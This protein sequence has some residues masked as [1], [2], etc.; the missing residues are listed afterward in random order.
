M[1]REEREEGEGGGDKIMAHLT[2]S[3]VINLNIMGAQLVRFE[4]I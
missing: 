1:R 2:T 4:L 3:F